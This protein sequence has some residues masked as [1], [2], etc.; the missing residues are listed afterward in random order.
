MRLET[1]VSLRPF[2]SFGI[3]ATAAAFA[4][5]GSIE[6]LKAA[7]S[8][9]S[10]PI[11][12]L[13]GGSNILLTK[14]AYDWLFIKNGFSGIKTEN[15]VR[16]T[17]LPTG[18]LWRA[19]ERKP[20]PPMPLPK[21][22]TKRVVVGGG[23]SWHK[24]VL[25]AID[26]GLAGIENLSLIPGTVGAAPIQNIGA[27]GVEL[28]DVF[29]GLEAIDLKTFELK[30]FT[31]EDCQF[32]YRDSIFKNAAKGRYLIS[33]LVLALHDLSQ[34][35]IPYRVKT[36]YGDVQKT[37]AEMG[38]AEN[39]S[40]RAVSNAIIKIRQSK[41]P[42]PNQIGNAGSFFKNPTIPTPQYEALKKDF[43][44]LIGYPNGT[45]FVKVAAGYLIEAC[46]WKGYRLGQVGVHVHQALVL[47]NYGG[48]RGSELQA[49]AA[50]IQ[51]SV[52]A[53]FGI[54]LE[55]EVNMI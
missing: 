7:L 3:E 22:G 30:W 37:L 24:L 43:P 48:G 31:A 33:K 50:E 45:G 9:N 40:I 54:I 28:K 42:D 52:L 29:V 5:V 49:L 25:W 53:R 47:V 51:A 27:Y 1:D 13:G 2:N 26:N 36:A 6:D 8:E 20:E 44:A 34:T 32:G 14:D 23:E 38:E 55:T 19:E 17:P 15:A 18:L 12:L 4:E 46:G 21:E 10:R 35:T 11:Y 16:R 41:L 39:P